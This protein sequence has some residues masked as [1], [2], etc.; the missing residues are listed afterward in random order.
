MRYPKKLVQHADAILSS[1]RRE[2]IREQEEVQNW[3][4]TTHPAILGCQNKLSRLLAR[5]GIAKIRRSSCDKDIEAQIDA[6]RK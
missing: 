5:V 1:R 6:T 4:R 3:L 2:A